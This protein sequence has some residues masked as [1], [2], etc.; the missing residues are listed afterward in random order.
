MDITNKSKCTDVVGRLLEL[1]IIPEID[2]D[3]IDDA[4]LIEC[5][6]WAEAQEQR[7]LNKEG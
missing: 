6:K 7:T 5:Q 4:K 3:Y 2:W 1:A